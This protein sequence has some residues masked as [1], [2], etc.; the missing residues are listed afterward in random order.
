MKWKRIGHGFLGPVY[1]S[2][3]WTIRREMGAN[4][5]YSISRSDGSDYGR[6]VATGLPSLA[7]AKREVERLA[8]EA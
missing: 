4:E 6:Q 5:S 8:C 2:A 7:E 1:Y 3:P